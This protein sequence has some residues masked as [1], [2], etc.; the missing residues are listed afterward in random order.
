MRAIRQWQATLADLLDEVTVTHRSQLD[1]VDWGEGLDWGV[2]H[3][4]DGV[5]A[6]FRKER[7]ALRYR[8]NL[9]NRILNPEED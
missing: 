7:D 3:P 9:I 8:L 1:D 5:V 2:V 4:D 6:V